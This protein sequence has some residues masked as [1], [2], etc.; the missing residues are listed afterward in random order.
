MS[1]DEHGHGA[2]PS[3]MSKLLQR[4][5]NL[6]G[7]DIPKERS[8]PFDRIGQLVISGQ[9]ESFVAWRGQHRNE[10]RKWFFGCY[11]GLSVHVRGA[12]AA[13]HYHFE[14]ICELIAAVESIIA[15]PEMKGVLANAGGGIGYPWRLEIEYHAMIFACRRSLDYLACALACAFMRESDSFR[16]FPKSIAR[17]K[18]TPQ[19]AAALTEAHARHFNKLDFILAE[20]RRSVR[21]RIAHWEFVSVGSMNISAEGFFFIGGPESLNWPPGTKTSP[22]ARLDVALAAR[23]DTVHACVADMIETLARG[24]ESEQP[25]ESEKGAR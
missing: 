2:R 16:T 3:G 18:S 14:R 7:Y 21:N 1:I 10:K 24:I 12:L 11:G 8:A 17:V 15:E 5:Q 9:F 13:A 19:I 23:L 22:P 6:L 4:V 20:G 25:P